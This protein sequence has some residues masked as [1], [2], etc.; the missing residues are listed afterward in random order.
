MATNGKQTT[1]NDHYSV[2]VPAQIR[3]RLDIQPG[4]KIR[5]E[6]TEDGSLTVEVVKERYGAFDNLDPV[7]MGETDVTTDHD[8]AGAE[9]DFN[10]GQ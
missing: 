8:I 1:V 10:E 6:V 7:E 3:N 2:T 4:D 9:D 5:W